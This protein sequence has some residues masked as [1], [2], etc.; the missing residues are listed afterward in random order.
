KGGRAITPAE[1]AI[2]HTELMHV[3]VVDPSRDDYHHIHPEPVG[4]S[5]A[6][7]FSFKPR[8]AGTYRVFAEFVPTRTQ[9]I[10]I[11]AGSIEVGETEF[12]GQDTLHRK[13]PAGL[14]EGWTA[15]LDVDP[16][17]PQVNREANLRLTVRRDD[18]EPAV[19][20][21]VMAAYAHLVAFDESVRGFAHLHPKF[22][23][24]EKDAAP[25][26]DFVLNTHIPGQY[27]IW[28]QVKIDGVERFVPFDVEVAGPAKS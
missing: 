26:L 23:G 15:T 3:L 28:A 8:R 21:P 22:T 20:E 9:Q 12:S 5:G 24:K 7:Q 13:A 4:A 27:R 18:G 16:T 17:T 25:Q 2:T 11:A 14:P 10:V 19:L 1:L 6:W